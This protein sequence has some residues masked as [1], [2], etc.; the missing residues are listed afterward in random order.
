MIK[1]EI[2]FRVPFFE[3]D[4][5]FF[6]DIKIELIDTIMAIHHKDPFAIQG[7]FPKGKLLKNNLTESSANF[8]EI[9]NE[10]IRK[11]Q[12]W[13]NKT[14]IDSYKILK[15]ETKKVKI[16]SSWFHVTKTGGFHNMH[17]HPNTP[18]AGIF[19][20]K[21]GNSDIG[22]SWINPITGY[23]DKFSSKWCK[24]SFTSKFVPGR[25]ILFPGW[26]LHSALPH[27]GDELRIVVAFNSI[28]AD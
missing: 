9:E 2:P 18:L 26:L 16:K 4:C 14:L 15:I 5:D 8:L 27:Q 17:M 10:S 13:I 21:D 6:H 24:T 23:I 19:Y 11:I 12:N 7:S 3:I 20:I 25:L 22:N 1:V 28:P